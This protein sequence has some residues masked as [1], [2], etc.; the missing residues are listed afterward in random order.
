VAEELSRPIACVLVAARPPP[1]DAADVAG[2][3]V[4]WRVAG[5]AHV[6]EL[7]V[8]PDA[9]RRGVGSALLEAAC[10]AAC[11]TGGACLLEVRESNS[12]A[13][14]LYTRSGF[15]L[16]GRRKAYYPDGEAALLMTRLPA[17]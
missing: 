1:G 13:V 6:M 2:V 9:R 16:V 5:D 8:R 7:A 17:G 14:A 11:S 15:T 12:G 3:A 4:A 10:A